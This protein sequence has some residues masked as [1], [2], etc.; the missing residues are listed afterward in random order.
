LGNV[1]TNTFDVNTNIPEIPFIDSLRY[2]ASVG[3]AIPSS[4]LIQE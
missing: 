4:I 3:L 2:A 1:W